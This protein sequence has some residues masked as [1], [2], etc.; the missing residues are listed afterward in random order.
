M[1]TVHQQD[2]KP[3]YVYPVL[4]AIRSGNSDLTKVDM[5]DCRIQNRN[6]FI[7][8]SRERDKKIDLNVPGR[9]LYQLGFVANPDRTNL[10]YN[11]GSLMIM[12]QI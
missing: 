3:G 8:V 5:F 1:A 12:D 9:Q 11:T 4:Q 7:C 10:K 2:G 6:L